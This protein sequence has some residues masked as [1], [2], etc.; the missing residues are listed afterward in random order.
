MAVTDYMNPQATFGG[1]APPAEACGGPPGQGSR[2]GTRGARQA[3]AARPGN[4]VT[5]TDY[6]MGFQ[7][8]ALIS[9]NLTYLTAVFL[10]HGGETTTVLC[11]QTCFNFFLHNL[12]S[13]SCQ[14]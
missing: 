6:I 3:A 2:G 7:L 11:Q 13:N 10:L 9:I 4:L 5:L 8:L 14:M 1:D 12:T